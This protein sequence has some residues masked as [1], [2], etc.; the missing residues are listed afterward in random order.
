MDTLLSWMGRGFVRLVQTLPLTLVA[1]VGRAGG[2][3]A[4]WIDGRHRKVTRMNLSKCLGKEYSPEQIEELARENFKRIG[5]T[6][7]CALRTSS[8]T[9]KELGPHFE[10]GPLVFPEADRPSR[11]IVAIGHFGNFELY[12]RAGAL[13]PGYQFA[14]TY[15]GLAQPALDRIFQDLREAS[16]CLYFERR[17][18]AAELRK[19]MNQQHVVLGLLSDQHAGNSGVRIPFF[20]H[21]CS[22]S[23]AA[24]LLALRYDCVLLTGYCFRI[25]LAKWRLEAGPRIPTHEGGRPRP[26]A[27]IMSDVNRAFEAAVRRDPANWFWVHNRWKD[28]RVLRSAP[29]AL[30]SPA[31]SGSEAVAPGA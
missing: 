3:L 13:V 20:G 5:E 31:T 14:T 22:T 26:V 12:A 8:M 29:A 9:D 27:A 28:R 10:L 6:F 18:Q 2:A 25:G 24:A 11:A 15:R 23:T 16:G 1:R 30:T 19:F 7:A 4:F 21:E 17:T